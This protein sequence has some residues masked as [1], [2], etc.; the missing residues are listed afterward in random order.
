M[1]QGREEH[2]HSFPFLWGEEE[3]AMGEEFVRV[4]LGRKKQRL[5][6]GYK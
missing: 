4:G 5:G 1:P 2:K 3:K 6:L